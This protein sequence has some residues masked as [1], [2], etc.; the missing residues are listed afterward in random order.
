MALVANLL[1]V[2]LSFIMGI[3]LA[4]QYRLRPRSHTLWYAVGLLLTAAAAFPEVY[5]GVFGSLPTILWWLYWVAASALVGFLGVGTA[6]LISPR[7]GRAALIGAAGLTAAL[8]AATVLTAGPYA[9]QAFSSAPTAYI[10]VPFVIQ[11]SVGALVIFGGAVY[12]FF[13]NRGLY[14]IWIALGALIFSAGGGAAGSGRLPEIFYFT[15]VLG[16]ILLYVGVTGA[17][18]QRRDRSASEPS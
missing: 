4:R 10:K 14:N 17:G 6:Y 8:A 7:F 1:L 12:S 9:G 18:V 5:R 16:I 3:R 15:Q 11:S 13:R 2:V